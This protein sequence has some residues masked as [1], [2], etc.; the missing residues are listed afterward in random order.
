LDL[1]AAN[2]PQGVK[3]GD[4][5]NARPAQAR[6]RPADLEGTAQNW[7][8]LGNGTGKGMALDQSIANF[9]R[10]VSGAG[11]IQET[12]SGWLSYVYANAQGGIPL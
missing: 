7:H 8:G 1:S 12:F 11:K 9:F 4:G 2:V 3:A 10:M 6:A 5:K